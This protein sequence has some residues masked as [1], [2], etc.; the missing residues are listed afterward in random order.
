MQRVNTNQ[1]AG[2]SKVGISPNIQKES[3]RVDIDGN[4]ID[5]VTKRIIKPREAEIIQK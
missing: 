2:R 1:V 4:V 3:E 5:P